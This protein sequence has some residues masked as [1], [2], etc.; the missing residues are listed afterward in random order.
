MPDGAPVVFSAHGVPKSV[1]AE[2]DARRSCYISMRPA[3]WSARSTARPNARSR[4]AGTSC[5]SATR[6]SRSDR[7]VRP[8][9]EGQMTLVETVED[10]DK[11]PFAADEAL[12]YLTQTTL[13]VDDTAEVIAALEWRYPKSSD[14]RRKTSATPR[15]T[16]RPRSRKSRREC[17][18]VLVIGAPNSSNSLRLVEVAERCGTP[19]QA[20]PARRRNRSG[21]ARGRRH[22]RHHRRRFGA[23]NAGSRSGRRARA[24]CA[25]SEEQTDH[26]GRR[27]DGVQ[28]AA[29]ARPNSADA[30]GRWRSTPI[31][32]PRTSPR[33]SR[34][35]DVGELVSA[36]G[37]AEGVSNS[38]WLI[39]TTGADRAGAAVHPD[40]VR[41]ADRSRRPAL[42]PRPARP[43]GGKG[44][45]GPAHDP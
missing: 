23:R 4:R 6:P 28:A 44:L 37:I 22:A 30:A 21:M 18:L 26:R 1:P 36:K 17:D 12:A 14:R 40:H 20:D 11:L 16:G 2:A 3:R 34:E 31:S 35:Y 19:A 10:V 42:L 9:A 25:R 24:G 45:P 5:S 41:T 13:S 32:A 15:P 39:E 33:S 38:N 29:P 43:P 8:G 27:K 7:H